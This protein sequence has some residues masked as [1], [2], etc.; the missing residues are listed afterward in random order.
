MAGAAVPGADTP[1]S[2]YKNMK[3]ILCRGAGTSG[4][5]SHAKK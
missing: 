3:M 1:A 4:L 5:E 2:V